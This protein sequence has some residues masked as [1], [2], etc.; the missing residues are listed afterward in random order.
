MNESMNSDLSEEEEDSDGHDSAENSLRGLVTGLNAEMRDSKLSLSQ[1]DE[2]ESEE[3]P[4][5]IMDTSE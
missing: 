5:E 4:S 1:E 3:D 2:S